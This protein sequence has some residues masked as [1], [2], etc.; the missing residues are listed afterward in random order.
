ML[1]EQKILQRIQNLTP[2][3]WNSIMKKALDEAQIEYSETPGPVIFNGLPPEIMGYSSMKVNYNT[4]DEKKS[5]VVYCS[6]VNSESGVSV[7]FGSK[8]EVKFALQGLALA[9]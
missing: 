5:P 8:P 2:D 3:E 4:S 6:S 1:D 9:A 7:K